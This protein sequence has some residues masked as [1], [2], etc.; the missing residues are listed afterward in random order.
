[1]G[2][3]FEIRAVFSSQQKLPPSISIM[4]GISFLNPAAA[5][6]LLGFGF[7]LL[8]FG[9]LFTPFFPLVPNYHSLYGCDHGAVVGASGLV[10][11]V[12]L[13]PGSGGCLRV[14]NR[15]CINPVCGWSANG[16]ATVYLP[17]SFQSISHI[18]TSPG[19]TVSI[20]VEGAARLFGARMGY[21]VLGL[22]ERLW[23]DV[24]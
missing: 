19:L 5:P 11:E 2:L 4:P 7:H 20:L 6:P 8:S 9:H 15:L 22:D 14:V 12:Y 10:V 13:R 18:C 3:S 16:S 1:M 21:N 17:I 24:R 23:Y